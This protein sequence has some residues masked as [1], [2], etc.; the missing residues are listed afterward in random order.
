MARPGLSGTPG[1]RAP[2]GVRRRVVL[3]ACVGTAIAVSGV[4]GIAPALPAL[5]AHYGLSAAQVSLLTSLYLLPSVASAFLSGVLAD[6]VG[7]RP[8]FAGALAVFG[9]CGLAV[10]ITSP[11]LGPLLALRAAQGAAFGAVL[12]LSVVIIGAVARNGPTAARAQGRRT[13]SMAVAEAALPPV[14]GLLVAVSWSAPFVLQALAVPV[15]AWAWRV[16]PD[17][18]E[19]GRRR[20]GAGLRAVLAEPAVGAV[21]VLGIVR[22]LGKFAI[23]TY[24]P[25]LAADRLG[26]SS[27]VIGLWLGVSAALGA[28][29]AWQAEVLARRWSTSGL[30][31][32]GLVAMTVVLLAIGTGGVLALAPLVVAGLL[33]HG[34]QDGV[35]GVSHN[36][37]VT[38][39]APAAARGAYVGLAATT[40][41]LGKFA[42]P[43]VLGGL[44]L[45]LPVAQGFLVMAVLGATAA[46]AARRVAR[47]RTL[48]AA[49]GG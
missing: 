22:F 29:A 16:V 12:A 18:L 36:V 17:A 28:L 7:T 13:M 26:M 4:Q 30:V 32:A 42:A 44:T 39:L 40:R 11:A 25:V 35:D 6:R 19:Q 38:E 3:V 49:A 9:L 31:A 27:A 5:Q 14:A 45:V 41:N 21:Q 20:A 1:T 10:V 2:D 47:A 43:L 34:L 24:L 23:L 33:L 8:V 46:P 15:A 48:R 37:L